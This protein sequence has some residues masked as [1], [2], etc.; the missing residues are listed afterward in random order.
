LAPALAA[1]TQVP[2]TSDSL[3]IDF[4]R[5]PPPDTLQQA[6]EEL[7]SRDPATLLPDVDDEALEAIKFFKCLPRSLALHV[8]GM[9]RRDPPAVQH[10]LGHPIRFVS[11]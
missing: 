6:V 11:I 1:I 3:S 2:T 9:R 5:P 10:L 4:D 8:L 7:R